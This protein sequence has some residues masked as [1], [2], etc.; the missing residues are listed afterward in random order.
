MV[1]NSHRGRKPSAQKLYSHLPAHYVDLRWIKIESFLLA[2][3]TRLQTELDMQKERL[4][5]T[6]A[7]IRSGVEFGARIW[8][9]DVMGMSEAT[10]AE[11][12]GRA[13]LAKKLME[14]VHTLSKTLSKGPF[15]CVG[16]TPS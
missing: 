5:S 14:D 2:Q 15:L 3:C 6:L 16:L 1:L 9:L 11:D 7:L 4:L 13:R 10:G 8:T 12:E